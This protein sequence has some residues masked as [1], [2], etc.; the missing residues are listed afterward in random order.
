[1]PFTVGLLILFAWVFTNDGYRHSLCHA[2]IHDHD[3]D[4]H[5]GAH[6]YASVRLHDKI[7]DVLSVLRRLLLALVAH[8]QGWGGCKR[9]LGVHIRVRD[10]IQLVVLVVHKPDRDFLYLQT[11]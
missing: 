6:A 1:M 11:S 7:Y 5:G 2:R 3:G 9:S 10:D 4:A 8:I